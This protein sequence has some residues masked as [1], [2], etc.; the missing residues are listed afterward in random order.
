MGRGEFGMSSGNGWMPLY[1]GDY[2]ADTMEL[3]AAQH[4]AYLLLLMFYWRNGPLPVEDAKLA[5]IARTDLRIWKKTVGPIVKAFFRESGGRLHQKRA[6]QELAKA[7]ECHQRAAEKR[8][9]DNERLRAWRAKVAPDPHQKPNGQ[10][11]PETSMK[12]VSSAFPEHF[13]TPSE[14]QLKRALQAQPQ[15]PVQE[16]RKG[17]VTKEPF[18]SGTAARAERRPDALEAA[19]SEAGVTPPEPKPVGAE[20]VQM[21]IQRTK[22]ALEMR[23]PY[24]ETRS[25]E[26]QL[27]AIKEQPAAVGAEETMGLRWRPA[28]P[29]RTVEE[30]L[31]WLRANP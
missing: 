31:A 30:Q 26:A 19:L 4:G 20:V 8:Q 14:T 27:D 24:G 1:I 25:V 22:K 29:I 21:A 12:R 16:E 13:E 17:E 11:P 28:E 18:F 10:D 15:L 6:D 3:D 9:T 5:Q 7:S 2:L 23:I